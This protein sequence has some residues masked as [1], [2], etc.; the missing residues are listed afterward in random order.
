MNGPL[1]LRFRGLG[2]RQFPSDMQ[3]W[4]Y[5]FPGPPAQSRNDTILPEPRF[6]DLPERLCLHPDMGA[7]GIGGMGVWVGESFLKE[8]MKMAMQVWRSPRSPGWPSP[9]GPVRLGRKDPLREERA[10]DTEETRPMGHHRRA[11]DVQRGVVSPL[12]SELL[13]THAHVC[14]HAQMH[15]QSEEGPPE[16]VLTGSCSKFWKPC[17]RSRLRPSAPQGK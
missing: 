15:A 14:T 2:N 4:T 3:R 16:I 8:P 12:G 13:Y 17:S 5:T 1:C 9:Q 7:S 11:V 10:Q 6:P